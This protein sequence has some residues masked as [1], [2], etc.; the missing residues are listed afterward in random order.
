MM[1]IRTRF[2]DAALERAI[3]SGATQVLVMGAG[4]DTHAYRCQ[5]LLARSQVFE[6]DRPAT[7]AMKEQRVMATIGTPPANLTYVSVDFE[8]EEL[9]DVLVRNGYNPSKRTFF[10]LEGVTM[11]LQEDALRRTLR[12]VGSHPPGSTIVFDF[13]YR[14]MVDMIAKID[15]KTV[16]EAAR[17]FVKRFLDLTRDEPWVFRDPDGNGA[18]LPRRVRSRSARDSA[19]RRRGITE[20]VRDDG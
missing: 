11:Y 13:V 10:I 5:D 4:F 2:V 15:M 18:R 8:H 9:R 14:A 20:A 19:D 16:P 12:F 1:I 17:A 7:Q 6:V 3:A